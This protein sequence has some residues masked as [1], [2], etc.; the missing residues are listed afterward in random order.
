[1][2]GN[3]YG[4][5]FGITDK[6]SGPISSIK[7]KIDSLNTS[8]RK[9]AEVQQMYNNVLGK[10]SKNIGDLRA[11]IELL[12]EERDI[13]STNDIERIR[14][15]NREIKNYEGQVRRLENLNGG[16]LKKSLNVLMDAIP[17]ASVLANPIV[18]ISAGLTAATKTSIDFGRGMAEVN[19]TA[20]LSEPL[21]ANLS[22][23]M[24]Q[25]AISK[26]VDL[27]EV[28]AG[29]NKLVS[30]TND[31]GLSVKSMSVAADISKAGFVSLDV[32]AT[33]LGQTMGA[34]GTKNAG[35]VAD[36]L[37]AAQREGAVTFAELAGNLPR[38]IPI[39]KSLGFSF[40]ELAGDFAYMTF[41]GI[42][43]ADTGT[44]LSNVFTAISRPEVRDGLR[45][46]GIELTNADGSMKSLTSIMTDFGK[47]MKGMGV[48]EQLNFMKAIG[49]NDAQA[50]QGFTILTGD[51]ANL[52][53]KVG[54]VTESSKALE[55][56][57]GKVGN[58]GYDIQGAWAALQVLM[59][60]VGKA[61]SYLVIPSVI[62][63]TYLFRGLRVALLPLL[64]VLTVM[65]VSYSVLKWEIVKNSLATAYNTSLT[66]MQSAANWSVA[67][68]LKAMA[69]AMFEVPIIGW[70]LAI[71]SMIGALAILATQWDGFKYAL[72]GTWE[73]LKNIAG[74]FMLLSTGQFTAAKILIE[75]A[76]TSARNKAIGGDAKEKESDPEKQAANA[77]AMAKG[78]AFDNNGNTEQGANH[79][80]E[81]GNNTTSGGARATSIVIENLNLLPNLNI[82]TTHLKEGA[83]RAADMMAG[84]LMNVFRSVVVNAR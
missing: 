70:V 60:D 27:M 17:G 32:A 30:I 64:F 58:A 67:V 33:T 62:I 9:L 39:A 47:T 7:D 40:E 21:L 14:L 6:L 61:A 4:L 41:K 79:V 35:H 12:K 8:Q 51:I 24:K 49:L 22:E 57:L 3:L 43:A 26:G 34:L 38:L 42:S 50:R 13:V 10:S 68:S 16:P 83:E 36:V 1:M 19:A 69:K 75:S 44:L 82:N 15:I 71:I 65:A 80:Q 45:G 20:Q 74:V 25:L 77:E 23:K 31:V 78:L 76:Y 63:I 52:Q 28:P 18:A 81:I 29:L 59:S 11:A 54:K 84:E 37:F 55:N 72:I 66:W 53:E 5:V 46:Y 48:D 56:A 2:T 73:V